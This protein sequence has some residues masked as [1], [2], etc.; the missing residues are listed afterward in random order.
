M[1]GRRFDDDAVAVDQHRELAGRGEA[2]DCLGVFRMSRVDH[3][4]LEG[5]IAFV[6]RDGRLPVEGGEGVAVDFQ[7]GGGFPGDIRGARLPQV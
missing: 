7:H 2:R 4:E 1:I 3:E 5:H 6:E